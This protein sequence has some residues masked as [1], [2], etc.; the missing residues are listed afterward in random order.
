EIIFVF[1]YSYSHLFRKH[2]EINFLLHFGLTYDV[3]KGVGCDSLNYAF[4]EVK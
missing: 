2:S 3:L 1:S 4:V